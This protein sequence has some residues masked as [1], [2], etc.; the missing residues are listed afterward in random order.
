MRPKEECPSL[1][2]FYSKSDEELNAILRRALENQVEA[3]QN[4]KFKQSG[5]EKLLEDLRRRVR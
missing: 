2:Y 1:N 3:L 4:V 5:E